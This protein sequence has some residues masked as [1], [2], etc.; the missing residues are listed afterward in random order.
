MTD[1]NSETRSPENRSAIGG[2]SHTP[3]FDFPKAN[4]LEATRDLTG[5][6][7]IADDGRMWTSA[8]DKNQ[9]SQFIQKAGV[10]PQSA[11]S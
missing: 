2:D 1:R 10:V 5:Y 4:L 8:N 11:N 6:V 9:V 3:R 7:L